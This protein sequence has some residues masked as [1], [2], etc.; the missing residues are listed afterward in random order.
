MQR[1]PST[2]LGN[3]RVNHFSPLQRSV[4]STL[5]VEIKQR[6]TLNHHRYARS[7]LTERVD[8]CFLLC[9]LH[10]IGSKGLQPQLL[11]FHTHIGFIQTCLFQLPFHICHPYGIR[12]I[13]DRG[14]G[15]GTVASQYL[16]DSFP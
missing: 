16:P 9:Q 11:H 4:S 1:K 6:I 2:Q 10:R 5:G 14:M 13:P 15:N 8:A 12:I 3:G 7:E